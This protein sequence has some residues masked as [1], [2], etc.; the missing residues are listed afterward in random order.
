MIG[1]FVNELADEMKTHVV[2]RGTV[3]CLVAPH[4]YDDG[5][6]DVCGIFSFLDEHSE[7]RK[8]LSAEL[9]TRGEFVACLEKQFAPMPL[10]G[11]ALSLVLELREFDC[12]SGLDSPPAAAARPL[13]GA[14]LPD[15]YG[16]RRTSQR[17]PASPISSAVSCANGAC[18][19]CSI[20]VVLDWTRK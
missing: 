13:R 1:E 3:P 17:R 2:E 11:Y 6:V 7:F 9:V 8:S 20:G 4:W 5:P 12:A 19:M 16:G 14:R 10:N 15:V 18:A